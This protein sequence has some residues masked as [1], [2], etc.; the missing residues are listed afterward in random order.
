MENSPLVILLNHCY[1]ILQPVILV[2][3][4]PSKID[5]PRFW[6]EKTANGP[7]K[8]AALI[9]VAQSP[10]S[11]HFVASTHEHAQKG[12]KIQCYIICHIF[13]CFACFRLPVKTCKKHQKTIII[14]NILKHVTGYVGTSWNVLNHPPPSKVSQKYIRMTFN[15]MG[16]DSQSFH[17]RHQ[18]V[19]VRKMLLVP[20]LACLFASLGTEI[21]AWS[22]PSIVSQPPK[23]WLGGRGEA[24][25]GSLVGRM[26][27]ISHPD[28]GF[29][30]GTVYYTRTWDGM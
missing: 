17:C 2:I 4:W 7:A 24:K 9:F 23:K 30:W 26:W 27:G 12:L 15:E 29:I 19:L 13:A 28:S 1:S 5:G 14:N 3:G 20:L 6:S 10:S 8:L 21:A 25:W 16:H 18:V 22:Q 11:T